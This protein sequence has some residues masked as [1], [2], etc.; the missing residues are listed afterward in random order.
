MILQQTNVILKAA[1]YLEDKKLFCHVLNMKTF[2]IYRK[3]ERFKSRFDFICVFRQQMDW[4]KLEQELFNIFHKTSEREHSFQAPCHPFRIPPT[5]NKAKPPHQCHVC[6]S[7]K[8]GLKHMPAIWQSIKCRLMLKNCRIIIHQWFDDFSSYIH[9]HP[10][11]CPEV[12]PL[13]WLAKVNLFSAVWLSFNFPSTA[14][15]QYAGLSFAFCTSRIFFDHSLSV[16]P[17]TFL[18]QTLVNF[19]LSIFSICP[20]HLSRWLKCFLCFMLDLTIQY[21]IANCVVTEV[22]ELLNW[23]FF[24]QSNIASLLHVRFDCIIFAKDVMRKVW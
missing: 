21:A 9:H 12:R 8:K 10:S 13:T 18:N 6:Y 14:L 11:F 2:I 22:Q 15:F 4:K 20:S 1:Q 17:R 3:N 23:K 5:A 7:H 19:S 24:N 16:V